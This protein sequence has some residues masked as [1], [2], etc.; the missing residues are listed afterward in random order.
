MPPIS[1]NAYGIFVYQTV[2]NVF[3]LISEWKELQF[4]SFSIVLISD[5]LSGVDALLSDELESCGFN[6]IIIWSTRD[7][8]SSLL[9]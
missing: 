8:L 2:V 7:Q 4:L 6:R 3:V 5:Y 9:S 1:V